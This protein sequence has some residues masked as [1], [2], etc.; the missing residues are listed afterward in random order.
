[1]FFSSDLLDQARVAE[2]GAD[3]SAIVSMTALLRKFNLNGQT[4]DFPSGT[5]ECSATKTSYIRKLAR[6]P[7][8]QANCPGLNNSCQAAEQLVFPSSAGSFSGAVFTRSLSINNFTNS[9]PSPTC[10]GGGRDAVWVI[11]PNVGTSNRQFTVSTAGSNFS[12]MISVWAGTCSTSTNSTSGLSNGLNQVTCA[13][14]PVGLQGAQ[15][16]FTTDGRNNFYIVGEGVSGQ[17][18]KLKIKITSP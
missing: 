16:S 3:V 6:D 1:V 10:G 2:E 9:F 11:L 5:V 18:G 8:T 15:L 14:N 4:G 13:V 12:T 17:Y 7:T